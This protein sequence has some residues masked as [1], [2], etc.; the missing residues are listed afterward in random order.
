MV[1][2]VFV[3]S[4]MIKEKQDNQNMKTDR[5]RIGKYLYTFL[6]FC[7]FLILNVSYFIT[8]W[9]TGND[10][11]FSTKQMWLLVN[12]SFI[13]SAYFFSDIHKL[14]IFYA[15][16]LVLH[17]IRNAFL[18]AVI[19]AAT[20]YAFDIYHI[21]LR[22]RSAILVILFF[23][24]LTLWRLISRRMLKKI[25]R[26]GL[27]FRRVIIVGSGQTAQL[28]C[29]EIK[30]DAGYGFR[31]MGCFDNNADSLD[32]MEV[33]YT[34]TLSDVQNFILLNKIDLIYYTIDAENYQ[35]IQQIMNVA[36]EAGASFVYVPKFSR[37]LIGQFRPACVGNIPT[38]IHSLSPLHKTSNKI[39]KRALDLSIS[40]PFLIISPI[41]FIPIAIAIKISSPGPVFFSQRRTG[42]KGTE[43]I[44]YK[45]RSMRI[46]KDSDLVQATA[47]D[48]RK[49][50]VGDFLRRTSLDEL[51]QF[52]NVF[53]GNMSIVGP[54]PHMVAQT[55]EYSAMIDKYMVRHAVK[56]GIT[57][58]AQ[59]N[60]Y[61]GGTKHLWQMEKRVEYDVWYIRHWNFFLDLKIIFLTVINSL[62]GEKNAY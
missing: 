36:D 38:L 61:R 25:R 33:E 49:T 9:I 42:I 46:N 18:M 39:L 34:G 21:G 47:D 35:Q 44:C 3:V 5:V 6:T 31:L 11:V 12:L 59:V 1:I 40:V 8:I 7:D 55:E 41:I 30:S 27:N 17:A 43:F 45:F 50:K 32:K 57:G 51:P 13:P 29:R 24:L 48:P 26:M 60:G 19:L 52:F 62:R 22:F 37:V 28:I 14:R 4:S 2:R 15:D 10:T 23:W 58:W 20:L 53:I 16:R 56:P 54:R